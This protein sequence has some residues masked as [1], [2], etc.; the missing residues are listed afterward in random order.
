MSLKQTIKV[1]KAHTAFRRAACCALA[2]LVFSCGTQSSPG[3][4]NTSDATATDGLTQVHDA[5][6]RAKARPRSFKSQRD[7]AKRTPTCEN[8]TELRECPERHSCDEH[9]SLCCFDT[10]TCQALCLDCAPVCE[11]DTQL[12]ECPERHSCDEHGSLCCFDKEA[13]LSRCIDC[14]PVC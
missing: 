3:I 12:R 13:C 1:E 4:D 6:M 2:F 8:R 11:N 10:Y 7:Q 14:A 9:G 5:R